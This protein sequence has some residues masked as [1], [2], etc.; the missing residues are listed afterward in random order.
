MTK[1]EPDKDR[2]Q[3]FSLMP[4]MHLHIADFKPPE[5]I[6][7]KFETTDPVLR[8]YFYTAVC[9]SWELHSPYGQAPQSRITYTDKLSSVF[10][11]PELEGKIFF[12]AECRQSHLSIYITPDLLNNYLGDYFTRLPD[13]LRDISEGC[14]ERGFYHSGPLPGMMNTAIDQLMACPYTGPARRLYM[15]S[16]VV[17]LIAHKIAQISFSESMQPPLS[18][19]QAQDIERIR[20]A[21]DILCGDLENPPRLHDLARSVGINHCKLN[22]GF[23]QLFGATVFGYLRRMRLLEAKRLIDQGDMN[24]TEVALSVGYNSL[25]SFSKAFS[26]FFGIPPIQCLKKRFRSFGSRPMRN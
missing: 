2:M 3:A 9:G 15:E 11:Y 20:H 4:G 8:F 23:R 17:E 19:L 1:K 13:T 22:I 21:R 26:D 7:Q 24:V 16:K 6:E 5:T 25:P 10:F 14:L 12:P 18:D